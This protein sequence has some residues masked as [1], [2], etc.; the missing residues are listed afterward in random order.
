MS[1]RTIAELK[2]FYRSVIA[3][4]TA[5]MADKLKAAARLQ[6]LYPVDTPAPVPSVKPMT[7]ESALA[8]IA[9]V[10]KGNV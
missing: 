10:T 6:K 9:A 3:S 7:R 2:K 5:T 4:D 8:A 1:R